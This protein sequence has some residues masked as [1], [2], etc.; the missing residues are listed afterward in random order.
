MSSSASRK[1][2]EE[3][4]AKAAQDFLESLPP[5][6]FPE[7]FS[8]GEQRKFT[9]LTL[10]R[11]ASGYP[12]F[13]LF[14]ELLVQYPLDVS[15]Q[16]TGQVVP[17][18]MVVLSREPIDAYLSF[19]LALQPAKP[20]WMLDYVSRHN[21]R[22]PYAEHFKKFE[23]ELRVPYYLVF[24]SDDAD[25]TLY[26]LERNRY[27][28][29]HPNEQGRLPI[30]ELELETGLVGKWMR[31]WFRGKLLT[32]QGERLREL[33]DADKETRKRLLLDPDYAYLAK[34]VGRRKRK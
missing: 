17:D 28:A 34:H 18:N 16:M 4:Y 9:L 22:K 8:Q 10:E 6:H 3:K 12:G 23:Q 33:I 2:L 14:N 11:V 26:H 32:S 25:M 15:G 13:R 5:E 24:H 30:P 31:Y 29:V 27:V 1:A 20:F 21:K 19:D 7:A